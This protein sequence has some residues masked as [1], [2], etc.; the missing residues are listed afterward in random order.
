MAA[1]PVTRVQ[2]DAPSWWPAALKEVAD[3]VLRKQLSGARVTEPSPNEIVISVPTRMLADMLSESAKMAELEAAALKA[4]GRKVRI[5]LDT[6]QAPQ[7]QKKAGPGF[8]TS[9]KSKTARRLIDEFGGTIES[10]EKG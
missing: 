8:G 3:I 10:I 4:A 7:A 6:S 2:A 9:V 5:L 1:T